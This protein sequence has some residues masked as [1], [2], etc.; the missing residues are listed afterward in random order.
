MQEVGYNAFVSRIPV[1]ISVSGSFEEPVQTGTEMLSAEAYYESHGKRSEY[2]PLP[3]SVQSAR[4][5]E[6]DRSGEDDHRVIE[7]DLHPRKG[8][9]VTGDEGDHEA[10]PGR[11]EKARMNLERDSESDQEAGYDAPE[12]LCGIPIRIQ[13]RQYLEIH[14]GE[15]A[16]GE[17]HQ[18][19]KDLELLEL[20][21]E[22][23]FLQQYEDRIE[24]HCDRTHCVRSEVTQGGRYAGDG[25]GTNPRL[26]G[27]GDTQSHDEKSDEEDGYPFRQLPPRISGCHM[28]HIHSR[29]GTYKRLSAPLERSAISSK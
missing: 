22:D 8:Y 15:D 26:F 14:I 18:N 21:S 11:Y 17:T 23:D 20:F 19:L 12:P 6:G 9:P 25:G 16:D 27:H 24:D 2:G 10:F 13:G 28:C 5:Y 3:H 1:K 7:H 4:E 29:F